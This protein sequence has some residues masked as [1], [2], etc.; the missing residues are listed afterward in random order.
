[1]LASLKAG[2]YVENNRKKN[3]VARCGATRT[4][5]LRC[6]KQARPK[7]IILDY[8]ILRRFGPFFVIAPARE[9]NDDGT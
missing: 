8:S 1:M 5:I 6:I 3:K 9:A 2:S 7:N 4:M